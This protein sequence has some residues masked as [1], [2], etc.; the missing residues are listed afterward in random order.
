VSDIEATAAD[1]G[2]L[3]CWAQLWAVAGDMVTGG[4]EQAWMSCRKNVA[5]GESA[6][7]QNSQ[8]PVSKFIQQ[9]TARQARHSYKAASLLGPGTSREPTHTNPHSN[10]VFTREN[11]HAMNRGGLSSYFSLTATMVDPSAIHHQ[12]PIPKNRIT[13]EKPCITHNI[14]SSMLMLLKGAN[15]TTHSCC[16]CW[17]SVCQR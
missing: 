7:G 16:C 9:K 15:H 3:G 11:T 17:A 13:Y 4:V 12:P 1:A 14:N 5:K 8:Q 2:S 10:C 6:T